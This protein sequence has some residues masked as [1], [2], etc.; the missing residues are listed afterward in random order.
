MS[1]RISG[2]G[3]A[4]A[5]R[6]LGDDG[7]TGG[8]PLAAELQTFLRTFPGCVTAQVMAESLY[9]AAELARTVYAAAPAGSSFGSDSMLALKR[10][11][12]RARD[13]ESEWR[14]RMPYFWQ[15]TQ[16]YCI[17]GSLYDAAKQAIVDIYAWGSAT[18]GESAVI[19]EGR[20]Q[21]V[22]DIAHPLNPDAF[23]GA[24]FRA[25]KL[26]IILGTTATAMLIAGPYAGPFLSRLR[27][28]P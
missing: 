2:C 10:A 18:E 15:D 23:W 21:L 24:F 17:G 16:K 28:S 11:E 1:I 20:A 4:S 9:K 25:H 5:L 13:L 27:K 8:P 12:Q 7:D 3:P 14:S 26:A 22:K 19:A 6:G